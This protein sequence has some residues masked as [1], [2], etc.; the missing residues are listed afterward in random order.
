MNDIEREELM[1][2]SLRENIA[3]VQGY[4]GETI[5]KDIKYSYNTATGTASVIDARNCSGSV[6]IEKSIPVDGKSYK[7]TSIGDQAFYESSITSL[8]T[9]SSVTSIGRSA[10]SRCKYLSKVI[11]S[12]SVGKIDDYAFSGCTALNEVHITDMLFWCFIDFG[13]DSN[14][15]QYGA[16]LYLN[17]IAVTRLE[18]PYSTEQ[19]KPRAFYNYRHVTSVTIP[20]TLK[21]IGIDAF[22]QCVNLE[23]VH[24]SDIGAWCN[25][26]FGYPGYGDFESNP[27]LYAHN[28]Y[29]N[30]QLIT[31]FPIGKEIQQINR[32]AFVECSITSIT[33]LANAHP[34]IGEYAFSGCIG[35]TKV[36]IPNY[37]F[38][39]ASHTFS[40]CTALASVSIP[41]TVSTIGNFAFYGC[42]SLNEVR[43]SGLK[44][45]CE[46]NFL[47]FRSNPLEYANNLYIQGSLISDLIIPPGVSKISRGL[48]KNCHNVTSIHIPD[49][50]TSIDSEAFCGCKDVSLL[51]L[52]GSINSIGDRA[53]AECAKIPSLILSP[54]VTKIGR[55]AFIGCTGLS[56]VYITD[57]EAWCN[58]DFGNAHS[59]PLEYARDLIHE[60]EGTYRPIAHLIIPKSIKQ[61]KPH[62]F[63]DYAKLK[64]VTIHASVTS[65]GE[66]AFYCN[67]LTSV[68]CQ[69]IKPIII[70]TNSFKNYK[71]TLKVPTD[72]VGEYKRAW[73]WNGFESIEPIP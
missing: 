7:V 10:F 9:G 24:I 58:I 64:S 54:S 38:S 13:I 5:Y 19:I 25:I 67:N 30:D 11:I 45:W 65:I 41:S 17:L 6:T 26:E 55:N 27:L 2:D 21:E 8:N 49:S 48:F 47:G 14:P 53:F 57:I 3:A 33:F 66:C 12:Y 56:R 15:L 42:R 63:Q 68:T 16:I 23:E 40:G 1:Q 52:S 70:P 32:G 20:N 34:S 59:N 43:I 4:V 35:L 31:D 71:A 72:S 22:Y 73:V 37:I 50:V 61:I 29:F 60:I 36:S 62:I 46:I 44:E 69:I 39:I 51:T 28:L 18:I